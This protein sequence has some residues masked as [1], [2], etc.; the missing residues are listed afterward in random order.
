MLY[1]SVLKFAG[2][3]SGT[4]GKRLLPTGTQ[5]PLDLAIELDETLGLPYDDGSIQSRGCCDCRDC[6]QL[7]WSLHCCQCCSIAVV[8]CLSIVCVVDMSSRGSKSLQCRGV[9]ATG[10]LAPFGSGGVSMAFGA[11]L[12]SLSLLHLSICCVDQ[13]SCNCYHRRRR[14]ESDALPGPKAL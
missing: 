13:D 6:R 8:A 7:A 5:L 11:D 14:Q 10:S 4:A 2:A 3:L 12:R 1:F 9:D